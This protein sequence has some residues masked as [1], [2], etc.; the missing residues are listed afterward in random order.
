MVDVDDDQ[1]M[2][3]FGSSSISPFSGPA[4]ATSAPSSSSWN[5]RDH[6]VP[7]LPAS[8]PLDQS[9]AFVPQASAPVVAARIV[10]V[11][12]ARSIDAT[13]DVKNAKV[14][15]LSKSHVDFRIRLYRGRGE[16]SHGIIVEVQREEG[17]DS[18][19]SQ[20]VFAILDAAEGK[21]NLDE[22]GND[23]LSPMY[24]YE[25]P[26]DSDEDEEDMDSLENAAG[27]ASLRIISEILCPRGEETTTVEGKDFAL[28][29]LSSLTSLDRMGH[30][31]V[32]LS[33]ELLHSEDH[34]NLRQAVFSNISP[35][36]YSSQS[37]G[38]PQ[39][40]MFQSLEILANATK[41]SIQSR[42]DLLDQEN[43]DLL[44]R[45]IGIIEN[46]QLSPHAADLSCVILKNVYWAPQVEPNREIAIPQYCRERLLSALIKA[47]SYGVAYHAELERSS[48]LCLRV[49][50]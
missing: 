11:L 10:S 27:M 19:Y 22:Y 5:V 21:K 17:F 25:E 32:Q 26:S 15:C 20:D 31:A 30:A 16:Y 3:Y 44:K 12:Q 8:Y 2:D 4:A 39:R 47:V 38:Y 23:N 42:V 36:I 13:F 29:S 50:M 33:D 49:I 24:C 40:S 41:S 18:S 37:L 9:A 43:H 7:T 35:A 45:L 28:S 6:N 1:L 34:A 14:G 48:Q 46:A